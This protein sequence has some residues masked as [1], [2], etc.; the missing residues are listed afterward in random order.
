M[1]TPP[2]NEEWSVPPSPSPRPSRDQPSPTPAARPPAEASQDSPGRDSGADHPGQATQDRAARP[3]T[4]K[5][6][7]AGLKQGAA[8]ADRIQADRVSPGLRAPPPGCDAA[9][10]SDRAGVKPEARLLKYTQS[11]APSASSFW[12]HLQADIPCRDR[13]SGTACSLSRRWQ[14]CVRRTD[15][16]LTATVCGHGA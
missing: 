7:Q 5:R 16:D 15:R 14:N 12:G 11:P 3:R 6:T 1:S 2:G 10:R 9:P 8:A 13:S 4:P